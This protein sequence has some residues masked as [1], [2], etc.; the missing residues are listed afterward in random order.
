MLQGLGTLAGALAV[1]IAALIGG[2]TFRSWRRQQI[3]Q[4]QIPLAERIL[5]AAFE[6]RERLREVRS[7]LI[8]GNEQDIARN[9]ILNNG[10][11]ISKFDEKRKSNIVFA[12]VYHERLN[13]H[14]DF[15][16]EL[17]SCKASAYAYFGIET[18]DDINKILV[19]ISSVRI[20]A[21]SKAEDDESDADFSKSI[22]RT[23]S[24]SRASGDVDELGK[25]VDEAVNSIENRLKPVLA[26]SASE[27][28]K[29]L[30]EALRIAVENTIV[31]T[32]PWPFNRLLP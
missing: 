9:S 4:R 21:D 7:P 5:I 3:M 14:S 17:Q 28:Q 25:E 16:V 6:A 18:V 10:L 2:S 13:R 26:V 20:A 30:S 19:S 23:L 11:D 32:V 1:L 24:F 12:Q 31:V 15:W 8:S 27:S 29:L 22:R